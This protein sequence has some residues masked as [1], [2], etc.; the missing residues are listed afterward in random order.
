MRP[1]AGGDNLHLPAGL[2]LAFG[3]NSFAACEEQAKTNKSNR[4]ANAAEG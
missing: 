4:W 3:W 2:F 1:I